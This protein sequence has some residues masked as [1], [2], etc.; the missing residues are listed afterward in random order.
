[1]LAY[2]RIRNPVRVPTRDAFT[3]AVC[4]SD[5]LHEQGFDAIVFGDRYQSEYA[6]FDP[7]QAW[8]VAS[9]P[10]Y[11]PAGHGAVERLLAAL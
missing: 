8:I 6:I 5:K 1:M 2:L 7:G 10:S 4:D 11:V 9:Y 3:D